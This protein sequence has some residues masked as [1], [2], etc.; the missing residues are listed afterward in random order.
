MCACASPKTER[1][2]QSHRSQAASRLG[3]LKENAHVAGTG[4]NESYILNCSLNRFLLVLLLFFFF[5]LLTLAL[6][7]QLPGYQSLESPLLTRLRPERH[8]QACA[9]SIA[10]VRKEVTGEETG[11]RRGRVGVLSLR[12]SRLPPPDKPLWGLLG[13]PTGW[14]ERPPPGAQGQV[15]STWERALGTGRSVTRGEEATLDSRP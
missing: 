14:Q 4:R 12:P 2:A 6:F 5:L 11:P 8:R 3:P 13:G 9:A 10:V 7:R 15:S 1:V